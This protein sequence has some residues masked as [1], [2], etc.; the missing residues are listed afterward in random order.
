MNQPAVATTQPGNVYVIKAAVGVTHTTGVECD[1]QGHNAGALAALAAGTNIIV[2]A[3][4]AATGRISG[5]S[6]RK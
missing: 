5:F 2:I 6:V 4:G 1:E 3:D